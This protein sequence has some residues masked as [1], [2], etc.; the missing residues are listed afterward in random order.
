MKSVEQENMDRFIVEALSGNDRSRQDRWDRKHMRTVGTKL[1]RRDYE[2]LRE[3]CEAE[4]FTVYALLQE[5]I[6]EVLRQG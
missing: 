5:F 6:K 1:R 3:I 4:G 2:R